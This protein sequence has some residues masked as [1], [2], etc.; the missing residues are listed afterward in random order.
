M[1]SGETQRI[2]GTYM[3]RLLLIA[4]PIPLIALIFIIAK[5]GSTFTDL[6]W[7]IAL[8]LL[9]ITL[10]I[11]AAD[12]EPIVRS[13]PISLFVNDMLEIGPDLIGPEDVLSITPLRRY[14]QIMN[15]LFEIRYA[16]GTEERSAL[17][18]SKPD[19]VILGLFHST[20]RSI[21]MLLKQFPPLSHKLQQ[22]KWL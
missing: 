22:A 20:P 21:R 12:T 14:R 18:M 2:S 15:G 10:L 1:H 4:V 7:E 6:P 11:W 17:I 19:M 8:I 13:K 9:V 16:I 3:E 5:S